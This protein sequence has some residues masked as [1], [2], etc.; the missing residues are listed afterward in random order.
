MQGFITLL[1]DWAECSQAPHLPHG[2]LWALA[3][4][5]YKPSLQ[6]IHGQVLVQSGSIAVTM[7]FRGMWNSLKLWARKALEY[8]E[9]SFKGPSGSLE[10]HNAMREG[11]SEGPSS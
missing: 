1:S 4:G 7:S 5:P 2:D 3:V 11:D 9:Q 10:D 8:Y 6:V